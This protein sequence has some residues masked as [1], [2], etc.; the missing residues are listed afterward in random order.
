[1]EISF[2][3]SNRNQN[4]YGLTKCLTKSVYNS[5]SLVNS[6]VEA[7]PKSK[8]FAG[9]LPHEF[10]AN[11]KKNN[12]SKDVASAINTVKETFSNITN[13]L[14]KTVHKNDYDCNKT[15]F[16]RYVFDDFLFAQ[17]RNDEVAMLKAI[18]RGKNEAY[19]YDLVT[20]DE[21]KEYNK[22]LTKNLKDTKVL[23]NSDKAEMCYIGSGAFGHAFKLSF[24]DKNNKKLFHD[25]VLKIYKSEEDKKY[26]YKYAFDLMKEYVSQSTEEEYIK[27]I[28]SI[29]DKKL[30][31]KFEGLDLKEN[32]KF[33]NLADIKNFPCLSRQFNISG[34]HG[35]NAEANA[36][37]FIKN[38]VGSDISVS[39]MI[40]PYC[41]DLKN[42]YAIVE[43]S[44]SESKTLKEIKLQN[45]GIMCFDQHQNNFI[46]DKLIDYGG[47]KVI[48][49]RLLKSPS[50]WGKFKSPLSKKIVKQSNSSGI[51]VLYSF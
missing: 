51:S 41:F 50:R 47:I 23:K 1:M 25:K 8:G 36:A 49:N 22:I 15:I 28:N 9:N 10:I 33:I 2:N 35:V 21:L 18:C 42:N 19:K 44:D 27:K 29:K 26:P 34:L 45:L 43:M 5:D 20:D 6:F 12:A 7:Y 24:L 31:D 16:K 30:I 17:A 46:N 11:I 39:N 37:L 4:F 38:A 40:E 13:N 14:R 48:D 3:T 32:Y